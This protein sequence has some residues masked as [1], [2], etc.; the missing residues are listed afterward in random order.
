[1]P[2]PEPARRRAA[3]VIRSSPMS[4]TAG[5]PTIGPYA[6]HAELGHLVGMEVGYTAHD[7][8]L[9]RQVDYQGPCSPI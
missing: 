9:D 4:L 7:P 2:V 1:M 5:T 6:I 8:R 3:L